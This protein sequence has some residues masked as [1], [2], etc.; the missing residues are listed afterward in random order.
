MPERVALALSAA[1]NI[2]GPRRIDP[3]G[4]PQ[5]WDWARCHAGY[6]I[7]YR[8]HR[9]YTWVVGRKIHHQPPVRWVKYDGKTA[10]VPRNPK[11]EPGKPPLNREQGVFVVKGKNGEPVQLAEYDPKQEIKLLDATPKEFLKPVYTPLQRADEPHPEVHTITAHLSLPD[12]PHFEQAHTTL[13][14][15]HKS[16]S[17]LLARQVTAGGKTTTVLQPFAG[18]NGALQ[19]HMGGV[20]S[21]GNY[22][23]HASGGGGG[24]FGGSGGSS[25]GGG[26]FSGGGSG[27]GGASVSSS[28]SSA[29]S[30]GGAHR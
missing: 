14:F 25:G 3:F 27:G 21:R 7:H 30:A 22:S 10:F 19:A 9:R 20:D 8:N 1:S 5:T 6:W 11:D 13:A 24:H 12:G 2:G 28:A 29:S 15:D 23:M 16:Q 18:H 17:F 26:H 4:Y